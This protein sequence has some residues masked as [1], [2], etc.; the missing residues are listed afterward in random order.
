MQ[1]SCEENE[2]KPHYMPKAGEDYPSESE[3]QEAKGSPQPSEGENPQ[4]KEI[5]EAG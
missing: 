3:P 5:A 2:G 4:Q 1:K